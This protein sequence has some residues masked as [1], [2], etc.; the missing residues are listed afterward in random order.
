MSVVALQLRG[1][2]SSAGEQHAPIATSRLNSPSKKGRQG[3]L[4][5]R[6]GADLDALRELLHAKLCGA[7]LGQAASTPDCQATPGPP[8]ASA[9]WQQQRLAQ[10]TDPTAQASVGDQ[11]HRAIG[12]GLGGCHGLFIGC[13]GCRRA[14]RARPGRARRRGPAAGSPTGLRVC[15]CA[16]FCVAADKTLQARADA[17]PRPDLDG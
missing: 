13:P 1:A 5:R 10:T 6:G 16:G 4:Q 9:L 12:S 3:L 17:L 11:S 2:S 8:W 7:G 14:R 15:S